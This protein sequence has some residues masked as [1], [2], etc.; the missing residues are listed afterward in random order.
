MTATEES[1]VTEAAAPVSPAR[2]DKSP[3]R[4]PEWPA[5]T[6]LVTSVFLPVTTARRTQ[7]VPLRR[8]WA[9]H[10]AGGWL[11]V[12]LIFLLVAWSETRASLDPAPSSASPCGWKRP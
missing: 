3:R 9:V 6:A 1:L 10:F 5:L 8:A 11:V 12:I 2:T 4:D 7:H